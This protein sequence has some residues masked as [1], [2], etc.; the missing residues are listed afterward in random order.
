M[1]S[2]PARSSRFS[3]AIGS[4]TVMAQHIHDLQAWGADI[5]VDDVTYFAEPFYQDGIIAV[6]VN[7]VTALGVSYFSSAGN[8]NLI[9][10]W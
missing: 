2:F 3:T 1:T 10:R 5:I 8:S 9:F 6:A 7:D 4:E